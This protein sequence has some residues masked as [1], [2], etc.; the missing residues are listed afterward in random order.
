VLLRGVKPSAGSGLE[1]PNSTHIEDEALT[2]GAVLAA[3]VEILFP[4]SAE[5]VLRRTPIVVTSKTANSNSIKIQ[6]V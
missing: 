2:A 5:I 6:L 4:R 1:S 3:K